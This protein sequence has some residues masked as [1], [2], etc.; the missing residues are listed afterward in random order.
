VLFN[1]TFI[2]HGGNCL[3]TWNDDDPI[4]C[5]FS[6]A[7]TFT[8][9]Y[10]LPREDF[11]TDGCIGPA[12]M[13]SGKTYLQGCYNTASG[14]MTTLLK[15]L[16]PLTQPYNASPWYYTGD[17]MVTTI[18]A[19]VTDWVLVQLRT[20]P[21]AASAVATRSGFLLM[22]G[23]ITDLD[24]VSPI[25]FT[26][27]GPGNYYLVIYHRNHMAVM[28][29]TSFQINTSG[30]FYDFS[31]GP[32]GNYGGSS[33]LKLVDPSINRWGMYSADPT[34][35]QKIYIDDYT[36]HWVPTF[37]ITNKYSRADFN[38]DGNV[39]IDDYTDH[40]VPNFGIIN[41]LP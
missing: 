12:L 9:L 2:Y 29:S 4:S 31:T 19:D 24:G 7:S 27:V 23:A 28:S 20:L 22:N 38:M 36:D 17:E 15:N 32:A 25:S 11:Y 30:G 34:N 37:G 16:M 6:D 5:E 40:W 8:P 14:S 13:V 41:S 1:I 35:D 3:L 18:P 26:G 21:S 39:Y 10:D 33:G